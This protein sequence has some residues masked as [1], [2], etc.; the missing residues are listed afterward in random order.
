MRLASRFSRVGGGLPP[1]PAHVLKI[2]SLPATE[3]LDATTKIAAVGGTTE[4]I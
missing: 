3:F 2:L 4:V 1:N